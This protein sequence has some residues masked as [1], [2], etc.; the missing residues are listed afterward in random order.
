ME[1]R[2]AFEV[3]NA[4]AMRFG[5]ATFDGAYS[6]NVAM[7]IADKAAFYREIH[8]V[9]KPGAWFVLSE[10]VQGQGPEVDYPTPWASSAHTSFLSTPERTRQ[11]LTDAGFDVVRLRDTV[12]AAL[13]FGARSRALVERGEKPPHRAVILIHGA[14]AP[15]AMANTARALREGRLIPIDVL[16]RKRRPSDRE[17]AP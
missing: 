4:L 7:N 17:A 6:M 13:A 16:A 9:L 1:E 11:D 10:N 15:A 14:L 8:R 3:G 2:V 12:A 5:E